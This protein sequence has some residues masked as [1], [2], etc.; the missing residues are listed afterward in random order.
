M[1]KHQRLSMNLCSLKYLV[2][3]GRTRHASCY[4]RSVHDRAQGLDAFRNIVNQP[5]ALARSRRR[6]PEEQLRRQASQAKNQGRLSR[7]KIR[8]FAGINGT[9]QNGCSAKLEACKTGGWSNCTFQTRRVAE[10][11]NSYQ[12]LGVLLG[13]EATIE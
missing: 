2:S 9:K 12:R 4:F 8:Q 13:Y 5:P 6:R 3:R 7:A 11:N 1:V 10:S